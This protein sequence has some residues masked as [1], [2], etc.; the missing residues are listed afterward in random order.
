ML[1]SKSK[2]GSPHAGAAQDRGPPCSPE[3]ASSGPAWW[4]NGGPWLVG[5]AGAEANR[6][7]EPAMATKRQQTQAGSIVQ[8]DNSRRA[9]SRQ[10]KTASATTHSPVHLHR[11]AFQARRLIG[12]SEVAAAQRPQDS[13]NSQPLSSPCPINRGPP[14]NSSIRY[15][16]PRHRNIRSCPNFSMLHRVR[17]F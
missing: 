16:P 7:R 14:P 10:A 5:T 2:P 17:N 12:A 4:W 9:C 11:R 6:A 13:R 1:N 8:C 15:L 3:P